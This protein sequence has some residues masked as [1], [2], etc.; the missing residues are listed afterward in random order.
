MTRRFRPDGVDEPCIW[1]RHGVFTPVARRS[2]RRNVLC[3]QCN[4]YPWY[5]TLDDIEDMEARESEDYLW[6]NIEP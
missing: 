3:A 1:C 4:F 6:K 5:P 2:I